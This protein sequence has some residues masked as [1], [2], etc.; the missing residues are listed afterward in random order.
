MIIFRY[1]SREILVTT[2]A[3]SSILLLIIMSGRFVKYLAEAA[4]GELAVEVLFSIMG[5]RLPGFIELILPLGFF[6]AILLAYGRLYIDSEMVVLSACGISPQQLVSMTFFP[7]LLISVIVGSLTLW[8]S[9]TGVRA[10]ETILAEQRTRSEFDAIQTGRFQALGQS[11]SMTYVEDVSADRNRL[12]TVFVAEGGGEAGRTRHSVLVAEYAEQAL[13]PEYQQ[14]YFNLYNGV[15]YEGQPG[16]ADYEVT[17][18]ETFG[19]YIEPT[20]IRSGMRNKSDAWPTSQ[21]IGSEDLESRVTLQWRLSLPLMVL[22][23]ALLAVPLSHTDPRRGRYV[24]ML[25]AI[26]LYMVYLGTLS[27]MRGAVEA[28]SWPI[29]PGLW[30]VHPV[31]IGIALLMLNW[32]NLRLWRQKRRQAREVAHA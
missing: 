2:M 5:F 4:A 11:E 19:Q 6:I 12:Q 30:I 16:E 8:V 26:L 1:L 22:V 31:F 3:V 7:A 17:E 20:D 21:L 32:H 15:R 24:K 13:H 27:G 18:F 23:V 10:T 28:G 29:V 9:P 14:R 25:P